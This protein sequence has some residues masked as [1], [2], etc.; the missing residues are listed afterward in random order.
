MKKKLHNGKTSDLTKN[1]VKNDLAKSTIKIKKY[2][3]FSFPKF[4]LLLLGTFIKMQHG[5]FLVI[6]IYI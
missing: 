3:T 4:K 2:C 5:I 1:L 6:K